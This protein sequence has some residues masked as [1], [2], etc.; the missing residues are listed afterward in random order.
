MIYGGI[1]N[2]TRKILNDVKIWDLS[3][4]KF[5]DPFISGENPGIRKGHNTIC[6]Y[7]EN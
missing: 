4:N 7:N 1:N 6:Y 2:K 3:I 5:I